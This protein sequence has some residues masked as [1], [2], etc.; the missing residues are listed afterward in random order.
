MSL[1]SFA[2]RWV[3]GDIHGLES[4]KTTCTS[5][6]SQLEDA[7]QALSRQVSGV[8]GDGGWTGSTAQSFSGAWDKDSKA[9]AQLAGAWRKIGSITDDLARQLASLENQ[10]EQAADQVEKQG[11][12]INP[13]DGTIKPATACLAP[14]AEAKN[15]KLASEYNSLR[16]EI[17]SRAETVRAHA[18]SQLADVTSSMVPE[19]PDYGL[20]VAGL[21]GMRGLWAAPTTYNNALDAKLAAA[22][23][24][25]RV[26]Q[27]AAFRDYLDAKAKYGK[28][29]RLSPE[30]GENASDALKGLKATEGKLASAPGETVTTRLAA[31]DADGLGVG[32]LA[33]GALKGIPY[34]GALA[35]AGITTWDDR[36]KGESWV[37]SASDGVVSNGVALGAGMGTATLIGGGSMVAVA[38]GVVVGGVVAVGVGD[39]VHNAFQE[40]WSQDIHD[41]GVVD[42]MLDGTG[43]VLSNTG[44]DLADAGKSIVHGITSLF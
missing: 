11:L 18:A 31:G 8:V 9:G 38:G 37:H 3:G 7:D 27:K 14:K 41:H 6:A 32:G 23:E 20:A 21:D 17:L 43:H 34:V 24:N 40:N 29:A 36:A 10:L 16:G 26:T 12:S 39:F 13:A 15:A 22:K 30:A 25:V 2:Y 33:G 42:G 5:T 19:G 1:P 35:G 4:F 28:A 44:H